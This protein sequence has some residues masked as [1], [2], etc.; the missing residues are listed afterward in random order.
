MFL[1]S[2]SLVI[3]RLNSLVDPPCLKSDP[4]FNSIPS[5]H[6]YSSRNPGSNI[7]TPDLHLYRVRLAAQFCDLASLSLSLISSYPTYYITTMG[8]L[9]Y[10]CRCNFG[11]HNQSLHE[12]CIQCGVPRCARC[13]QEKNSDNMAVQSHSHT[14]D[15]TSPYPAAVPISP[16]TTPTFKPTTMSIVVPELPRVMALP[17]PEYTGVSSGSLGGI[18]THGGTH[19]Y[20]C[21]QC[22]DGPKIFEVQPQC[23]MCNHTACTNCVHVK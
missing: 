15:I 5:D 20:V 19:M 8:C 1:L 3:F 11:P 16:P 13:V 21:C 4:S 22:H 9:W 17:Q 2:L 14:C 12:A 7:Y 6:K 18:R 10:C 23:V